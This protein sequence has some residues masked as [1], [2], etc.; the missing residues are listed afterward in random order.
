M[1]LR[2]AT[3][4]D[5]QTITRLIDGVLREY[6]DEICLTGA[7]RDLMDITGHYEQL[8][9]AFVVLDDEGTIRGTHAVVPDGTRQDVFFLRRLYLEQALR[10][11]V[12]GI[13][14]MDW[15]LEWATAHGARRIELWT[16]TR[17]ERAHAFF[18]RCGFQPDGRI[19]AMNDGVA[20]YRE[21]F[22]CREL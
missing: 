20:P 13:R 1:L 7:D 6:G 8:G 16:D 11:G 19:R 5:C 17:F 18:R 2:L 22:F 10:G 3:P 21:Y 15:T 12:W 14:L 9:G 4:Q